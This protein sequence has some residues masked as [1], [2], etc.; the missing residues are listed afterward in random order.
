MESLTR[1]IFVELMFALAR[2]A[3]FGFLLSMDVEIVKIRFWDTWV[4]YLTLRLPLFLCISV[5]VGFGLVS[6]QTE[7]STIVLGPIEGELEKK[8]IPLDLGD[9]PKTLVPIIAKVISIHGGLRLA[10]PKSSRY[11]CAFGSTS[12]GGISVSISEG[13][14]RRSVSSFTASE[15]SVERSTMKACDLM[16]RKILGIPGFFS[17][18]LCFLSNLSG[19]KEIFTG[20]AILSSAKPQTS[21]GKITFNPS[22][23]NSGQGIFFTSNRR[24]FNN[25]YHLNLANRKVETIANYRG[26]NLRG[27]QNPRTAQVALVLSTSG[28]PEIWIAANPKDRPKQLT[29]NKSNESGPT[30]SVDG[31][32]LIVTSDSRGKPQLYEVSLS[33]GRLSRIPTNVSSHCTEAS[34]NPV[35]PNRIAFTAAVSG[36]FQVCEYDFAA[37][38]SKILTQ[39]NS[40]SMQPC[41]AN[42]GRHLYMTERSQS[43]NTR[44][45]ILDTKF[46]EAKPVP[47]HNSSFGSC[48]QVSF[49]YP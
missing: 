25:V 23:D 8:Q 13:N 21:Y 27:V 40:H 34:W 49:F 14:P 9:T 5:L 38:R 47:L 48:S 41:W 35:D 4:S 36:G 3:K 39:G 44:I 32:R 22:W 2:I 20:N 6:A 33:T 19:K 42:D 7:R 31:R 43:G 12:T 18:K 11:T 37:R 24:I 16:V 17:G 15:G 10:P 1:K 28:N 46:P 26:S 29:R 45:M 30:W